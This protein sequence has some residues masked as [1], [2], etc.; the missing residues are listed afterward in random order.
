M[1]YSLL[2]RL[3]LGTRIALTML[4]A[5]LVI[6]GLNASAFLLLPRPDMTVFSARWLMARTAEAN[7][8]IFAAEPSRRAQIAE[9][10]SHETK[11]NVVWRADNPRPTRED[12]IPGYLERLQSSLRDGLAGK[13]KSVT[14]YRRGGPPGPPDSERRFVPREFEQ[15][16]RMGA[17]TSDEQ[18]IPV[19]GGFDIAIE[20]QDNSWIDIRPNRPAFLAPFLSPPMITAAGAILLISALSIWTA[21]RSLRPVEQLVAAARRLGTEREATLI[22]VSGLSDFAVVGQAINEMQNRIKGFI[23]ERTQ[24]LAAISHDLRTS[25][26]RLRLDAEELAEG[27]IKNDLVANMEEMER[28]VSATLTFAGDDLKGEKSERV[29]LAA[30]LITI[31]DTFSDMGAKIDYEGP[32]HAFAT[33]QPTAIRR[34]FVNVI[35]NA[36]K[37]GGT[38]EVEL[39]VQAERIRVSI[40]DRGPGIPTE[41]V[42]QAFR[43]FRRLETSRSRETSA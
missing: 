15:T 19:F 4:L 8:A 9:A 1:P 24:M 42:E 17:L 7:A 31:C 26:T 43:P 3:G 35:D 33:C 28:M 39:D 25:L 12:R 6:Q 5:T 29:D 30:L 23:D 21:K 2:S 16:L 10:L 41:L 40:K 34:A 38:A 11:L 13:V 36:I 27:E 14:V 37:Y 32:N 20:G 18:D 22:D